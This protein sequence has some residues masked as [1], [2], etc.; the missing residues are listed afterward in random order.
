MKIAFRLLCVVVLIT[1]TWAV[2]GADR[3]ASKPSAGVPT[4]APL[5]I[6]TAADDGKVKASSKST[7]AVQVEAATPAT[8]A[9]K[10][11]TPV[12]TTAA[13][14]P[15]PVAAP[16]A[17]PVITKYA[18]DPSAGQVRM[19]LGTLNP[20][21]EM[22]FY[23]QMRADYNNPALQSRLRAVREADERRARIAA[24]Q[25]YGVSLARPSVNT[26]PFT[27]HYS[28]S[29]TAN[30]GVPL[31]WGARTATPIVWR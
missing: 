16:L 10:P 11:A 28:A 1:G 31:I 7:D 17:A 19:S 14:Y 20:T 26:T 22:W 8:S 21:P 18:E 4:I 24:R 6:R 27:Y 23:E 30:A 9:A 12:A 3:A 13:Q 5:R 15:A 25:W 29:W 2:S